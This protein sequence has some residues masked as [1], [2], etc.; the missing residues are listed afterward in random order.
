MCA[1][2]ILSFRMIMNASAAYL[3]L[4]TCISLPSNWQ[5]FVTNSRGHS[6][7]SLLQ[8]D[9]INFINITTQKRADMSCIW[10]T[11]NQ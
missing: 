3:E 8:L 4:H 9:D 11:Q 5:M 1:K 7:S 6:Y 2:E 10:W